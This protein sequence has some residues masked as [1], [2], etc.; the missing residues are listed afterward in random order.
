MKEIKLKSFLLFN[1][2]KIQ[3]VIDWAVKNPKETGDWYGGYD[4]PPKKSPTVLI[5]GDQ[6]VYF[7]TG[8]AVTDDHPIAYANGCDPDKDEF[9]DWWAK[10]GS[11]WGGDDGVEVFNLAAIQG[12]INECTKNMIVGFN[13]KE[14]TLLPDGPDGEIHLTVSTPSS[15]MTAEEAARI[16]NEDTKAE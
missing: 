6:G 13:E 5:V 1:K 3:E 16:I 12:V 10:K 2:E 15:R 7:M 8:G 11:T 4:E 14:L 9:D